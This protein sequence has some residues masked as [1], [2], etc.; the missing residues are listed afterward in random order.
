MSSPPCVNCGR[1]VRLKAASPA[2]PICSACHARRNTGTCGS[3]GRVAILVGRNPDGNPWCSRCYAASAAAHLA[4][5]QREIVMTAVTL[6]DPD[7]A[8]EAVMGAIDAAGTRA[9]PRLSAHLCARP[10]TLSKGP[11][12]HPP[13]LGRFVQALAS[14]GSQRIGLIHPDLCRLRPAPTRE[15]AIR[16]CGVV[17]R[18]PCAAVR[19]E[20]LRRMR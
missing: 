14:A 17:R 2:G 16:R 11:N 15:T 5:E 20:S 10:E 12:S 1:Q 3:C 19:G 8:T 6:A 9:L 7:L 18:L 4:D 13:A